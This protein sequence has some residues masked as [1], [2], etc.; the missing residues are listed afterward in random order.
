[1]PLEFT[2]QIYLMKLFKLIG[3]KN[4]DIII[5]I[6]SSYFLKTLFDQQSNFKNNFL[7]WIISM[8]R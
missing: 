5:W 6:T 1:M 8:P 7:G 4:N 3:G 2:F